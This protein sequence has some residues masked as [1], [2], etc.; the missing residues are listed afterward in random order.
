MSTQQ[1]N[2]NV[3]ITF[4]GGGNMG[5]ALISGLLANG[6]KAHQLSVVEANTSTGFSLSIALR[7]NT[8]S[9]YMTDS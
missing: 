6:F 4:I 2:Q 1:I 5:R 3:H 8:F 7:P 9:N